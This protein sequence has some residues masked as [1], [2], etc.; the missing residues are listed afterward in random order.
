MNKK[1]I[2]ILLAGVVVF[3]GCG[4][5]ESSAPAADGKPVVALIMKSLANEFFVNM[6]NGARA[7]QAE[8]SDQYELIVNG[9]Q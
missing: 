9:L 8:N 7:H 4:S 6:A 2:S 1:S 3:F 5:E